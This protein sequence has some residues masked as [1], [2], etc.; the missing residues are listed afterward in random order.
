[1]KTLNISN[2]STMQYVADGKDLSHLKVDDLRNVCAVLEIKGYSSMKKADLI[3][4]IQQADLADLRKEVRRVAYAAENKKAMDELALRLGPD[5]GRAL[6]FFSHIHGRK[7]RPDEADLVCLTF[8]VMSYLNDGVVTHTPLQKIAQKVGELYMDSRPAEEFGA[9]SDEDAGEYIQRAVAQFYSTSYTE[10]VKK[11]QYKILKASLDDVY[12]DRATMSMYIDSNYAAVLTQK[13]IRTMRENEGGKLTAMR[14]V[15]TAE[16]GVSR[17][18]DLIGA[19]KTYVMLC[20]DDPVKSEY[21]EKQLAFMRK[22][23]L[24]N[25][26]YDKKTGIHYTFGVKGASMGRKA[27]QLFI[28]GAGWDDTFKLWFSL[29]GTKNKDG[30]VKAFGT[31][32]NPAKLLARVATRTSATVSID[33]ISPEHAEELKQAKVLYVRDTTTVVE[34]VYETVVNNVITTGKDNREITDSDGQSL[35]SVLFHAKT[36]RALRRMTDA[37]YEEF[38]ALWT[39]HVAN[40]GTLVTAKGTGR[41]EKLIDK[42]IKVLQIR[43][44]EKKGLI[45]MADLQT[46]EQTKDYDLVIPDS[47]RKFIGGEWS[48]Y[49]L[50]ICNYLKKKDT[51]VNLNPQFISALS[52]DN[53][54]TFIDIVKAECDRIEDAMSD[55][56]KAMAFCR[57]FVSDDSNGD[58]GRLVSDALLSNQGLYNEPQVQKWMYAQI[59]KKIKG[60]MVGRVPVP[61]MYSY[62]IFDPNYF[63]N[64]QFG[65]D[66]HCLQSGEYY[67]N[68][69][70]CECAALRSPMLHYTQ[71]QKV[72]LYADDAY[73]YLK[74]CL[75]F[76]GY[77][78]LADQMAG[79]D[80]D[81]DM[82]AI[83]TSDTWQGSIIVNGVRKGVD[84]WAPAKAASKM[85][86]VP[87]T[88]DAEAMRNLIDYL[89]ENSSCDN[90]GLFTNYVIRGVEIKNHLTSL[91]YYAE[92]T[93]VDRIHFVEAKLFGKARNYG[94]D[95]GPVIDANGRMIAKAICHTALDKNPAT[96]EC[97]VVTETDDYSLIGVKTLDEIKDYIQKYDD[98]SKIGTLKVG[99]EI[100]GAK[101]GYHP[102]FT[103]Q[104]E[105]KITSHALRARQEVLGRVAD[106]EESREK[107]NYAANAY[108]S[109]SPWGLT[110]S[111]IRSRFYNTDGSPK[112]G[113]VLWK[114]TKHGVDKTHL[115]FQLLTD[116]EKSILLN[117]RIIS[118]GKNI[119]LIEY[120]VERKTAYGNTLRRIFAIERTLREN[121][122]HEDETERY[123]LST[124]KEDEANFLIRFAEKAG[125]PVTVL[126]AA[127]YIA[128][129]RSSTKMANYSFAWLFPDV[130]ME[131]FSRENNA[132]GWM[133]VPNNA[134]I[135]SIKNNVMTVNDRVYCKVNAHDEY[136]VITKMLGS[137]RYAWIHRKVDNVVKKSDS[138][139][140][141]EHGSRVFTL[142]AMGFRFYE[143]SGNAE[144]W[145]RALTA[146]NYVFDITENE[147]G[148]VVMSCNGQPIAS[149]A[150]GKDVDLAEMSLI[151]H[152]VKIVNSGDDKIKITESSA[153]NIKV[154]VIR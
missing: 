119:S 102:E 151:G 24:A 39:A 28:E 111:Y 32:V 34:R 13:E 56:Q 36:T 113:T 64:Q 81:G 50:E 25:G 96:G 9:M 101:T 150:H 76:N 55:P 97:K 63:L 19:D 29:T 110:C 152:K 61:G 75:V 74:D 71:A 54:E 87:D 84:V 37:E 99:Y 154:V 10:N 128:T 26:F 112:E 108:V 77:D 40:G 60:M 65:T 115:M 73:W 67:H 42:I 31:E 94:R 30:F 46:F 21:S 1:M 145:K 148:R 144:E 106:T 137:R 122:E 3:S 82:C 47:V 149:I 114:L 133:R 129:Y 4:A 22:H 116:V 86:F 16:N 52:W 5:K 78:A 17:T 125:I 2:L 14:I 141:V 90:T 130:I 126:G 12:F 49:P 80:F 136:D 103:K 51:E 38:V 23:I 62:M 68:G 45:V 135:V 132:Y 79:A 138:G 123:K 59:E 118:N 124:I 89:V 95:F 53:P 146:T 127:A 72:Q 104:E 98:L 88:N 48:D 105:I 20:L 142:R 92:K 70:D 8:K 58:T 107:F 93:G 57:A 66:L 109:L 27:N 7:A 147:E 18:L 134:Q 131:I 35:G 120:L 69:K 139:L 121:K 91:I 153:T 6:A 41:L 140:M 85:Y 143:A 43:H 83:V 33:A 44:G 11:D 15:E 117:K 100:D